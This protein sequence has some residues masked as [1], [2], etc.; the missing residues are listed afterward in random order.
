MFKQVKL[1]ENETLSQY[2]LRQLTEIDKKIC[3]VIYARTVNIMG[4]SGMRR[5]GPKMIGKF[6][7]KCL[8]RD[9]RM[10][11][12]KQLNSAATKLHLRVVIILAEEGKRLRNC[13]LVLELDRDL[14]R[15]ILVSF[16]HAVYKSPKA[17]LA[18]PA[19]RNCQREELRRISHNRAAIRWK[20]LIAFFAACGYEMNIWLEDTIPASEASLLSRLN[21][22]N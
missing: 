13:P 18:S 15:S 3:N 6:A 1:N 9:R 17:G 21:Y 12:L 22:P 2:V 5:E 11:S 16:M 19:L 4:Y 14:T 10:P 20:S 8:I 7:Y